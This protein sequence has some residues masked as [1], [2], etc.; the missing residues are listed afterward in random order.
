MV[1]VANCDGKNVL[2]LFINRNK[3]LFFFV[4]FVMTAQR[5][6][7]CALLLETKNKLAFVWNIPICYWE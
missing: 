4:F 1:K 5:T 3:E 2:N 6:G 7:N